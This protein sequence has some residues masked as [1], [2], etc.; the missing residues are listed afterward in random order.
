MSV[1]MTFDSASYSPE[2]AHVLDL[3]DR[4]NRPMPL[5]IGGCTSVEARS[6]LG[7]AKSKTWFPGARSPEGALSGL[8]LYFGCF[9]EAHAVCQDLPTAEGSYW[10]AILHRQEPDPGNAAYW[11]RR[12]GRHPIYPDLR[13]EAERILHS[14]PS[15]WDPFAFIDFCE[16]ARR[17][18]G[19]AEER[20]AQLVQLVEWQL[21][22]DFCSV[23]DRQC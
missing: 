5:A 15:E 12:V 19:S 3:G 21:L 18:P 17:Q 8:W 11:F 22:F 23:P 16:A 9:D 4:G 20:A 10:H 7:T 1:P 14:Q 2:V 6:V 13:S